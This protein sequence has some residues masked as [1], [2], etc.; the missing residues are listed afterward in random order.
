MAADLKCTL[1]AFKL[2]GTPLSCEPYGQGHINQTKLVTTD[3]NKLY[4]LQKIN[5]NTFPDIE[6]L[7]NNISGVTEH[8]RRKS[9][10]PRAS[11]R[12]IQTE[13]NKS[14][15]RN[16]A[17]AWRVYEYVEGTI[18]LQ[19]AE[20]PEDFYESAV[21]FGKF[22]TMLS[23]FPVERLTETIKNFH[24]TPDRYRIFKETLRRDP[25]GRAKNVQREIDYILSKEEEMSQ[26]QILRDK[27]ALPSRVTHNDTKLNNVLFDAKTRKAVCVVDLDTV[28][29][30]LAAY[31][32]GDSI[33]FGAATAKEDEKNL[34]LVTMDLGLYE[35]FTKGFV[36]E[37]NALTKDEILSFPLGAKIMTMECGVRFFTD[38]LDGDNYFTIHRDG[39]N[40][41]RAR[42]QFKLVSDM[43]SK[44]DE[45]RRIIEKYF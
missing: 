20:I 6:G 36:S 12:V 23:D 14:W 38:Y 1:S 27:N 19:A 39:Q 2:D 18:A 8:I 26:L 13:D 37:C 28:M 43:D 16:D 11:M 33:R 31:D 29:P 3:K 30:G 40:L 42:T 34:D 21:G 35:C 32:F 5:E 25:L 4:V 24:N 45:M 7:M 9:S 10:D 22:Q 17:G 15:L 41:D 44:W